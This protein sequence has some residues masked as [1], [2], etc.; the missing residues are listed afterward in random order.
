MSKSATR[1]FYSPADSYSKSSG[2]CSGGFSTANFVFLRNGIFFHSII[3]IWPKDFSVLLR[4]SDVLVFHKGRETLLFLH[5]SSPSVF[6]AYF[7]SLWRRQWHPTLVLLPGE[8]HG[9]K[10]LV[11]YSPRVAKSQTWLS[12]FTFHFL[13]SLVVSSL[14]YRGSLNQ[15]LSPPLAFFSCQLILNLNT[16]FKMGNS[17]NLKYIYSGKRI[18]AHMFLLEFNLQMLKSI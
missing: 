14:W 3:M 8:S 17:H 9:W 11:G 10:S 13:A 7:L 4:L 6:L 5:T 15:P 1:M 18:T 2:Y 16:N 12:D